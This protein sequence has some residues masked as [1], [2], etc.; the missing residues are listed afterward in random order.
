MHIIQDFSL[1]FKVVLILKATYTSY[2]Y[3][4]LK[5]KYIFLIVKSKKGFEHL[6]L[7][8]FLLIVLTLRH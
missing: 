5:L 1:S 3:L 6:L 8:F 4:N 7:I 2:Y